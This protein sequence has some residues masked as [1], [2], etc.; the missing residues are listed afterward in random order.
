M[1]CHS[2]IP[3]RHQVQ[4]YKTSFLSLITNYQTKIRVY[5]ASKIPRPPNSAISAL[6][7]EGDKFEPTEEVHR[8][9]PR[10]C[11]DV[12]KDSIMPSEAKFHERSLASL[13]IKSKFCLL[14]DVTDERFCDLVVRVCRDP[15]DLGDKVTLYVSDYTENPSFFNYS[16][17]SIKDLVSRRAADPYGYTGTANGAAQESDKPA[18]VGPLGKR[19]IQI[20]VFEP[21]ADYVREHVTAGAWISLRNVQ[22]KY[23][24]D[25]QNLEGKLRGDQDYP[26]KINVSLVDTE[27]DADGVD[28]RAREAARCKE[29]VRR[30]KQYDAEKKIQL[31]QLKAAETAGVKRKA[32]MPAEAMDQ[33]SS[34]NSTEA[35]ARS[36][37]SLKRARK[38]AEKGGETALKRQEP[39]NPQVE[40]NNTNNQGDI[41][42]QTRQIEVQLNPHVKCENHPSAPTSSIAT[43]IAP[44]YHL[45]TINDEQVNIPL[46]FINAKY[47]SHVRVVDFYPH[48]LAQFAV[49]RNKPKYGAILSDDDNSSD[50]ESAVPD[51]DATWEWRFS[52]QLEDASPSPSP[53]RVWVV[54]DNAEGQQLT[55]LDAVDLRHNIET[56]SNLHDRMAILWGNIGEV[57]DQAAAKRKMAARGGLQAPPPDSSDGEG[58]ELANMPFACY[59]KQYGVPLQRDGEAGARPVQEWMRVFALMGT[60]IQR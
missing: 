56:L 25:S 29:A 12:N 11:H 57:K 30:W 52:L 54:V 34:K 45:T 15:Y 1:A 55:G 21:H 6:I 44:P 13:N 46:P 2:P 31:K 9:V 18:W 5:S 3:N 32:A 17:D 16:L 36:K 50:D 37:A 4:R 43:I 38:K 40:P 14:S 7:K 33:S 27:A 49:G 24:H 19:V 23:G 59:V 48:S 10:L 20:T 42:A 35:E 60:Q 47:R 39:C 8:Y 51:Q 28:R 41:P 53:Q 58:E 22:V 26:N